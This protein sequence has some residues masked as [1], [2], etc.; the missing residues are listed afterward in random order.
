[1]NKLGIVGGLGPMASAY[2]IERITEMTEAKLDQEH[3]E[4]LM[5][6][7]PGIPD[8]TSYILGESS[9]S[10]LPKLIE[11]SKGLVNSGAQLLAMPCITAQYFE[12]ELEKE[13]NVPFIDAI[14][15]T[16][17][18]LKDRNINKAALMATDGTVKCGLF[19][20]RL[21]NEGIECILP[22]ADNQ[23][24]IMDIIYNQVKSG[25]IID[26]DEFESVVSYL[27][28]NG[29]QVVILGCTEL[30]VL[31]RNHIM[32]A[33]I[34]DVIDVMSRAAVLKCGKLKKEFNE[35]ITI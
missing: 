6:S 17:K 5:H 22:D 9:M 16:A 7:C 15:E 32:P 31:K 20:S 29:A 1:M 28:D 25:K 30:S 23:A 3:I 14:G 35:L 33:G 19:Q 10:P 13:V 4:I 21:K 24:K 18:Y 2:Y 8:R 26:Y 34:L 27:C 12:K 11:V